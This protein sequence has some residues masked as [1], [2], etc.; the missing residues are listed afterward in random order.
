MQIKSGIT[1]GK[2]TAT[3][4]LPLVIF[5]YRWPRALWGHRGYSFFLGIIWIAIDHGHYLFCRLLPCS[6]GIAKHVVYRVKGRCV[7]QWPWLE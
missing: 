1:K 3:L 2:P 6:L 7:P 4:N 5:R